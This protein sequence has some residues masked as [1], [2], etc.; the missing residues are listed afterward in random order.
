MLLTCSAYCTFSLW[1]GPSFSFNGDNSKSIRSQ[2]EASNFFGWKLP[3]RVIS[4]WSHCLWPGCSVNGPERAK[5]DI[6]VPRVIRSDWRVTMRNGAF[7]G[8]AVD[9]DGAWTYGP[10][11]EP[12]G[13]GPLIGPHGG[14]RGHSAFDSER[15]P[16]YGPL[17]EPHG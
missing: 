5:R 8:P 13:V 10:L 12:H 1:C 17:I 6:G 11:I 4:D 16:S 3:H 14:S 7:S 15:A 2:V 9:P